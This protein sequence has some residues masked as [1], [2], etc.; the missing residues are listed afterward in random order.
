MD[1]DCL[2]AQAILASLTASV[3]IAGFVHTLV[4][5]PPQE[6][7]SVDLMFLGLLGLCLLPSL[8]YLL[9]VRTCSMVAIFGACLFVPTVLAWLVYFFSSDGFAGVV[10]IVAVPFTFLTSVIGTVI[11]RTAP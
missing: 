10:V 3:V 5:S 1:R 2:P 7:Q 8:I 11:D 6:P 4:A 9:G